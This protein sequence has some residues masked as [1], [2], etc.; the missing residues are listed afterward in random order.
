MAGSYAPSSLRD[1]SP[2][3]Q[4]VSISGSRRRSTYSLVQDHATNAK[5]YLLFGKSLAV[6]SLAVFLYRDYGLQ[7]KSQ[8]SDALVSVFR[9]EF[10]FRSEVAQENAAFKKLFHVDSLRYPSEELFIKT[11]PD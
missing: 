10:G 11:R 2:F 1:V 8:Y 4:V 3:Q 6:V 5:K 9:D 7:L